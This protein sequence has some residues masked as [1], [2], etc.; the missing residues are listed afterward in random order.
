MSIEMRQEIATLA[1]KLPDAVLPDAIALLHSLLEKEQNGKEHKSTNSS[2]EADFDRA[3][4][5]YQV[6]GK[7]Y[8]N[9]LRELAK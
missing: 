7:K 3:M 5:A 2:N 6:I 8:E 9:A 4:A 1:N